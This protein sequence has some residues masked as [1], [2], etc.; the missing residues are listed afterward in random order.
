VDALTGSA[1]N[2]NA[3]CSFT[4]IVS[5][6]NADGCCPAGCDANGDDDCSGSCGNDTIEPGETCDP[7]SSCPIS[8]DDDIGCTVDT[9]TGSAANCNAA[10][11][12]TEIVSCAAGD[13]CCPAGCDPSNDDDCSTACGDG[14]ID[15]GETCDP[16]STCPTDCDDS[17]TCTIDNLTGSA[18]NCNAVCSFTTVVTCADGD[19]CCP[20]GCDLGADSDCTCDNGVVEPH[21]TCDPPQTCPTECA[22][23]DPCTEDTLAGT[24][25][26]CNAICQFVPITVCANADGC[27]PAGCMV[28]DDSDCG[29]DGGL[30][31]FCACRVGPARPAPPWLLLFGVALVG[32]RLRR[33]VG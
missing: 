8:C 19:A 17:Q 23:A 14:S 18:A 3:A 4:E 6:A 5:C 21:E 26:R 16:Q 22:D 2:C 29:G 33:Y 11:S 1:A 7:E 28:D 13:Q 24:P 15:A 10:C 31:G 32:L 12:F 20:V 30:E 27:C 25:E 9:L